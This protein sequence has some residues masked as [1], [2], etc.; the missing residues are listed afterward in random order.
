MGVLKSID[1]IQIGFFLERSK[2]SAISGVDIT[3]QSHTIA[4]Q[5]QVEGFKG[6]K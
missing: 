3:M 1:S 5:L 2:G 4:N 6:S